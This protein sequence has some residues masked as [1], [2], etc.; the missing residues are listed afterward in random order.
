MGVYNLP[1]NDR[2][3]LYQPDRNQVKGREYYLR[4]W[5][6]EKKVTV[7][8]TPNHSMQI[9]KL[10]IRSS[11]KVDIRSWLG[12]NVRTAFSK[13]KQADWEKQCNL[14]KHLGEDMWKADGLTAE[15][16][17][18]FKFHCSSNE[19]WASEDGEC[20]ENGDD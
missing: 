20:S 18:K 7:T 9:N 12:T 8:D 4:T 19:N 6:G 17:G 1:S 15:V 16:S 2:A 11:R 14:V 10:P 5:N 13:I 3:L